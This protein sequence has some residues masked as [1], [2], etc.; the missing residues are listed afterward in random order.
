MPAWTCGRLLVPISERRGSKLASRKRS[1]PAGWAL[2]NI[3]ADY[4]RE[5]A[6]ETAAP[7]RIASAV[8]PLVEFWQGRTAVDISRETCRRF[9]QHRGRS[10]GTVRRELGVLR[11]AINHAFREGRL[12]RVVSVRL[13]ETPQGR[14][15]WLTQAE[16]LAL[17]K[18]SMNEPGVRL[19]LPLFI[20]IGLYTGQR[21]EAILSLRWAQVDLHAGLI[22][23]NTPG[24]RRTNKRRARVPI[25]PTLLRGLRRARERGTDLGYVVH[26]NGQR[27]KDIKRGFSSACR[28]AGLKDVTPHTLRHTC[29][30]WL[31]QRG[32]PTWDASG[33]L[34]MSR[35][36]LER[37]YGH[38]HP[39]FLRSAS[40]ALR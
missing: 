17:Y 15:R 33:Y 29:A 23:F 20:L 3:L 8:K 19:H 5:H 34:G 9:E 6:P 10:A 12:T 26:E 18:A 11:A 37:V 32:V 30:T 21:K 25:P 28:R 40:E 39:D 24:A 27:L 35:E 2:S 36:T 7:W 4:A 16:A 22:D 38:H 13:P 14:D 1:W 31:M